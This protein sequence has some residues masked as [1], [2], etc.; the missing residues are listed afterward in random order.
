MTG[1]TNRPLELS[2]KVNLHSS[3]IILT[4]YFD[5]MRIVLLSVAT[6]NDKLVWMWIALATFFLNLIQ[7]TPNYSFSEVEVFQRDCRVSSFWSFGSRAHQTSVRTVHLRFVAESK[8]LIGRLLNNLQKRLTGD[9]GIY[10]HCVRITKKDSFIILH[11][12]HTL[13][14][15][16]KRSK[17]P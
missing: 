7:R 14:L 17:F 10:I 8:W 5:V 9:F 6:P 13:F 12:R 11:V 16:W 3:K 2:L 1:Q 15:F 4:R